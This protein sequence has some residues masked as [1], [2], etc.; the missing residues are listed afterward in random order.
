MFKSKKYCF[1]LL[2]SFL[3][4]MVKA[5][6]ALNWFYHSDSIRV[7]IDSGTNISMANPTM[8]IFY[9]LPNGNTTEQT[10]GKKM[11]QGDDWHY[12]IQHIGA[13]TRF[14]RQQLPGKNIVVIYLENH[15]RSWP[16][17]KQRH[18][19]FMIKIPA[20]IDSL[21]KIIPGEAKE[22]CLNGHSGG[23][24]FIF[25]YLSGVKTIPS[26]VTRISFIDS[27][28]GYDS[29]YYPKLKQWLRG[30]KGTALNVFAYNDS[31]VIY[32]G[33]PLVSPTGGT[34]YRSKRMLAH[35]QY[36]FTI[37]LVRDD[38]LVV[39]HS[40]DKR[41]QFY[42]KTNPEGRIFHTQQVE[43]NGFIHSILCGTANDSKRYE[44]FGVRGYSVN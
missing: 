34:W 18:K 10:I 20:L 6:E 37:D 41:I 33:K 2:F 36:D 32:Q 35:L 1:S 14:I 16:A 3:A 26:N 15:L 17:W 24:S 28:Y 23:G 9:A 8:I 7:T 22:I 39:Y 31:V 27:N 38:S 12:D 4:V 11:E 13:Q 44:Y 29:T 5:Q 25:G 42:F 40:R 19:D 30:N 21:V 43:L